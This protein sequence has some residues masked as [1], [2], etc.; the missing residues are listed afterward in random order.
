MIVSFLS[1]FIYKIKNNKKKYEEK[2][3][4]DF[5]TLEDK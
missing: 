4:N 3:R 1:I 2:T 5:F